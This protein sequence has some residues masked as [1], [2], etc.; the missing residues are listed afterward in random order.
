M[1]VLAIESSTSSAKAVLYDT[2]KGIVS[3]RQQA[4]GP[5][6]DYAG[7]SDAKEVFA[8]S[9]RLA[10]EAADGADVQAIALCST[11]HGLCALDGEMNPL[12]RV[13]SWNFTGT[14]AMCR[15]I[16]RDPS[17]RKTFY[18]RTGCMPHNTYP[19]HAI[20]Y[21][22]QQGM[23]LK[24]KKF[25]TQGGYNFY[26]LTGCFLE[27]V[28][29]QSGSGLIELSKLIY[30]S[31]TL[32][33]LGI[34]EEQLGTLADY[35]DVRPLSEEGA[36]LLGLKAGIPVVPAHADGALNQVGNYA[37]KQKKMTLSIGTSG[38]IRL[39]TPRPVVPEGQEL[40][41]YC[42][43]KGWLSGAAIQGACNCINW[44]TDTF[45]HK[46]FSYA[47]LEDLDSFKENVPVF[48]PFLYGERCPGWDGEQRGG[49]FEI[50]PDADVQD[51]YFSLQ[52]GILFNLLQCYKVLTGEMGIPEDIFVS[53]GITNSRRWV[54]MLADIFQKEMKV[55]EYPNASSMG[56][57]ALAMHAAG[58][59]D[60]IEDFSEGAADTML[61]EPDPDMAEYYANQ[62][63]RYLKAYRQ[64]R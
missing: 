7:K 42:G 31:F 53:G 21:F 46:Q 27:S 28:C 55:A 29:A 13:H 22:A 57:V 58:A 3:A 18:S 17:L 60:E 26:R 59:L 24:G 33:Y 38:A 61:V 51:F 6:I 44:F 8:L 20:T 35:E 50:E 41:C 25:A 62:Y 52:M 36:R 39:V 63:E 64:N 12:T 19:R 5:A 32:D 9:A 48:L 11:Y 15:E 43:V 37:Q 56:A 34:K 4:Y 54:Q 2:E 49:F 47:A 45:L 14:A 40:W 16:R 10:R 30:D 1:L 23:D